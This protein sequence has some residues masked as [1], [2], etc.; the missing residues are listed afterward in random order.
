MSRTSLPVFHG[1][2][3]VT[4]WEAS[5]CWEAC[6]SC[7]GGRQYIGGVEEGEARCGDCFGTDVRGAGDFLTG[8]LWEAVP[9]ELRED[10]LDLI[11]E[12]RPQLDGLSGVAG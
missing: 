12:I 1:V 4:S 7:L 6:P 11:S 2:D 8:L 9:Y 5:R 3:I 10:I